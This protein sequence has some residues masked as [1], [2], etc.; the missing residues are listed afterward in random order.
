MLILILTDVRHLQNVVFSF[1]NGLNGRNH[2]SSGSHYQ[3]KKS[4]Q[5]NSP[6]PLA[7]FG[8]ACIVIPDFP[9]QL[10]CQAKFLGFVFLSK[11]LLT[12]QNAG[13]VKLQYFMN[14]LKNEVS[15]LMWIDIHRN[16]QLGLFWRS[17]TWPKYFKMINQP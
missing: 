3:I 5:Q 1:E 11:I 7:L 8:K 14:E 10:P 6:L 16:N 12:N 9:F 15:F 4:S 17:W 2:S 13:F